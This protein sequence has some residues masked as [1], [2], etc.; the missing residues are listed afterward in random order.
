MATLFAVG[1]AS[2]Q[3]PAGQQPAQHEHHH[4]GSHRHG[5]PHGHHKPVEVPPTQYNAD[6]IDMA[7]VAAFPEVKSVKKTA[8]W[9]EVYND[10]NRLLGYAVYSKPAS[11]NIKG[12]NGETPV[13]IALS[14]DKIITGVYAL[15]NAETPR[16]AQHVQ[17]AGFYN[18]WNGLGIKEAKKKKVDTVSGATFTSRA[19]AES[20]AA[21]LKDL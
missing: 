18:N 20:V 13:L 12:F 10:K 2:A 17:E 14:K 16:F 19:V 8:K 9:T 6:G 1:S 21:A 4:D 11:D 3:A 5:G 7:I 15:P